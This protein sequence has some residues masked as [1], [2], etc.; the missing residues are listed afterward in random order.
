MANVVSDAIQPSPVTIDALTRDGGQS[1]STVQSGGT[2]T[3]L[4]TQPSI[5]RL[6]ASAQSVVRYER[7]GD[8]LI[9]HLQDGSTLVCK[10]YFLET[11]GQHSELVFDNGASSVTHA[12]FPVAAQGGLTPQFETLAGIDPLFITHSHSMTYLASALGA[13]A[14]GGVIA[15]AGAGGGGGGGGDSDNGSGPTPPAPAGVLTLGIMAGDNVLNAA[16]AQNG[17]LI[18]GTSANLAPGSLVTITLG[19]KIYSAQVQQDGSWQVMLSPQEA[20]ALADGT[21]QV[22]A[23]ATDETGKTVSSESALLVVTHTLPAP[24]IDT[25]FGDNLLN[26]AESQTTQTLTGSTSISGA[27]QTVL[28]SLNGVSYSATV[29]SDGRWTL[30]LPP[31]VLSQL[32]QGELGVSVTATDAFGNSGAGNAALLVDTQPPAVTL[33]AVTGDNLL[34][35]IETRLPID[36]SGTT[37]PGAQIVVNYNN[38]SWSATADAQGNWLVTVPPDTLSDMSNGLYPLT[39]T[40]SD[41]AGNSAAVSESVVMAMTPPEPTLN[42]PFGD[43]ALNSQEVQQLQ[44]LSGTSG[45]FGANQTVAINI[46]GFNVRELAASLLGSDGRWQVTVDPAAGGNNYIATVDANGNWTLELP[47]EILQQLNNGEVSITVV[48]ADGLGNLGAT[49]QE[50]FEVDTTPPELSINPVAGDDIINA[51]ESQSDLILSGASLDLESGQPVNLTFNGVTYTTTVDGSGNWSVTVPAAALASLPEGVVE[52]ILATQDAAGNPSSL[53]HVITIDTELSLTFNPVAGD[54][55]IN[56]LESSAPI[57]LS[58]LASAD[59]AGHTITLTLNGVNYTASILSDG[60]W[61]TAV[62]PE[63][64]VGLTDGVYTINATLSDPAGNN[65]TVPHSFTL[66]ADPATLPTL[67]INPVAGDNILSAAEAGQPLFISGTTTNVEAGQ[68]VTLDLAGN[69]LTATVGSNGGWIVQVPVE[70]VSALSQGNQTISGQVSDT[71]GNPGVAAGGFLVDTQVALTVNPVAADDIINAAEAGAG[72]AVSGTADPADVGRTVSLTLSGLSYSAAVQADG[73]WSATVPA[74]DLASLADGQYTINASLT[75]A[76]GNSI[77]VPHT[78]TLD[79]AVTLTV[80]PVAADD[81]INAAEAGAGVAVSGTA[82]PADVGRTVSL[83]LSGLSYSAAV[84][85]DGSWSATVPAAD[86]ASLADGQYTINASLTDAAGNTLTVPHAI[87]L[88]ATAA[89]LPTLI[90]NAVSQNNYINSSEI[91]QPLILSGVTTNVEAGRT[92]ALEFA[93]NPLS[94]VVGA[95]GLWSVEVPASVITALTPGIYIVTGQVSDASGN[96]QNATGGFIVDLNVDLTVNPIATDDIINA[97][98]AGAGVVVSGTASLLDAEREVA[99]TLNG[100]SYSATVQADGSW[101]VTLPAADLAALADGPYTL[102]ASLADAAGNSISVPR[103]VTLDTAVALSVNPIA[104]DDVINAAEAATDVAIT[105]TADLADVGRTV[106]VSLN[107][108]SYSATVQADG[109]WSATLPAADL[110]TLADGPYTLT[111]SLA[112]A[113]G[114]STSVPHSVTLDAAAATLPTLLINA[115]FDDNYINAQESSQPLTITG[116]A[117]NVE[118]GRTVTLTLNDTLYTATVGPLGEWSTTIP[119]DVISALADGVYT[120][121]G[122]VSDASGNETEAGGGFTVDTVATLTIDPVATDDLINLTESQ[123]DVTV[124]GSASTAD[125]GEEVTVTLNGESWTT[126]IQDDGSWSTLIP[127]TSLSTMLDGLYVLQAT[128]TDVAGNTASPLREITLD[129]N[130]TAVQAVQAFNT[131]DVDSA[132]PQAWPED[133]PHNQS[134]SIGGVMVTQADG[135]LVQGASLAAAG[136]EA[137]FT[138]REPQPP[139]PQWSFS[140]LGLEGATGETGS[141]A[142]SFDDVMQ[143]K[144]VSQQSLTINASQNDSVTLINSPEGMWDFSGQ[145]AVEGQLFDVWHNS[146][147]SQGDPL[148]DVLIEQTVHVRLQ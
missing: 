65:L 67:T 148:G 44:L 124:S 84:Q 104:A 26:L 71:S 133:T 85:A 45:A 139:E 60:T 64:L 145:R 57:I 144:S 78:F 79:S 17:L 61:S 66:D 63:D 46:G 41:A 128:F 58:G 4:L 138:L 49:P 107:S 1:I 83:T 24:T 10:N 137:V 140:Q 20:Q 31:E 129:R 81:I 142:L 91:T 127:S 89:T 135:G 13:L 77:S 88:D 108:F 55:I 19:D 106:T 32:A 47:P 70:I 14:F 37:E 18:S 54:D 8:D 96:L 123:A 74:A 56:A 126:L 114:N 119:A 69:T 97:A 9:L 76:A 105:G 72:V 75:D 82:D 141:L 42:T 103:A 132:S 53:N 2:K 134:Y 130:V 33:N 109:S 15:A 12:A 131:L 90:I 59:V 50:Q 147:L 39:V 86:L 40:A 120:L 23:S 87:T 5:V 113:A 122:R 116:V 115:V 28:V 143:Q 99:V 102:T 146:A 36:I 35:L 95:D 110:A 73:S 27:G 94:A 121:I 48:A 43:G 68:T 30:T 62:P 117:F 80:N 118:E 25:A 29:D 6:H 21:V 38:L 136:E 101:S 22:R 16:E 51:L 112:D 100:V 52:I 11:D 98:E 7:Q 92:V 125:V 111:A 3:L 93:G 34:N